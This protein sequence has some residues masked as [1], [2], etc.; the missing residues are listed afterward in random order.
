[1]SLTFTWINILILFG[2]VN[3]LILSI[4]VLFQRSHP[5][6]KFFSVFMFVF[7][8]NG[9]ETFNWSSGLDQSF[10]FFDLF[11]F[12]VIYA[13]GPSLF[14]YVS[15]LLYPE[16]KISPGAVAAHYGL[17]IFQFVTRVAIIVYH[18]LWINKVIDSEVPSMGPDEYCVVLR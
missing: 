17:V 4:L 12:I 13:A 9:F 14:L 3:A 10:I 11:G 8:Y 15:S 6:A 18:L 7:A 2:A 5:G 1:M 16:K